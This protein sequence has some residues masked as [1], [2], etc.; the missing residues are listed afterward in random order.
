MVKTQQIVDLKSPDTVHKLT[1]LLHN[2]FSPRVMNGQPIPESDVELLLEA[3]RWAPS[4]N[5]RQPWHYVWATHGTQGFAS[6]VSLLVPD[7][8]RWASHAGVLLVSCYIESDAM[9]ANGKAMHD[10]GLANMSV[11]IQ[12]QSMGYGVRMMGG[13]NVAKAH[14]ILKLP[15]TVHPFVVLA[16]GKIGD[17]ENADEIIVTKDNVKRERKINFAH[18]L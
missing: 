12:A 17:Y 16:V 1:P 13:F 7:N 5:N 4:S 10:L 9:G 6:I 2:R 15:T 11:V 14:E 3:A 18:K 8:Q